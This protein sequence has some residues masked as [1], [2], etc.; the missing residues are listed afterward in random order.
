MQKRKEE[1]RKESLSVC[2]QSSNLSKASCPQRIQTSSSGAPA[3]STRVICHFALIVSL[4][5]RRNVSIK[6]S[7]IEKGFLVFTF[8]LQH[9]FKRSAV[10]HVKWSIL[11]P[12]RSLGIQRRSTLVGGGGRVRERKKRR[13]DEERWQEG[14]GALIE[15]L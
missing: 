7:S 6:I 5:Q 12:T 8:K 11:T 14:R 10:F 2:Q 9:A 4:E 1:R 13:M 15:G 3:T